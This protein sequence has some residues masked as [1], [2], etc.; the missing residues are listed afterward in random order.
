MRNLII[1]ITAAASLLL[2]ACGENVPHTRAVYMLLD[3]SGTYAKEISK[4][5]SICNFLL[6]TLQ[7]GDSLGLARIDSG[8]FSEKDIIAK[9]SFD[10]RP[11]Y[12]NQQK[13]AFR[14]KLDRFVGS[15]RSSKHTDITGGMLQAI[16]W[17]NETGA[18][19]KFILVFSDFEEDVRPGY[20]R[21]FAIDVS[22][23]N[24]VALNVTKLSSDQIDPRVYLERLQKWQTRVETGG[25]TW[26]V[27]NDLDRLSKML[28]D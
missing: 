25:G 19:H 2:T 13:R 24:V 26:K 23:I 27:I 22:G 21:D 9:V 14:Q 12:A 6:G 18:G 1:S 7:S 17:L 8:S 10:D 5:Q 28:S 3:T 15:V 16:E 4:A 11:S 20:V